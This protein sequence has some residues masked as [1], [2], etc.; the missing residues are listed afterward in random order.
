MSTEA[1]ECRFFSDFRID[2]LFC[3]G[4]PY[5]HTSLYLT[6]AEVKKE[7]TDQGRGP[8]DVDC[9][10]D[11]TNDSSSGKR[12][13]ADRDPESPGQEPPMKE[14]APEPEPYAKKER[15]YYGEMDT[16]SPSSYPKHVL[17]PTSEKH[18]EK[19]STR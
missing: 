18:E 15:T 5:S 9:S 13:F 2:K 8:E 14:E 4:L 1:H 11:G 16:D 19:L 7:A 17:V 10:Q 3:N 12:K 6:T